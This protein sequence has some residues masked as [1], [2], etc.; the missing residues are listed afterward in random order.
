M[1]K[2][3]EEIIRLLAHPRTST[4]PVVLESKINVEVREIER[5]LIP[6]EDFLTAKRNLLEA[7]H[8]FVTSEPQGRMRRH[9]E[10]QAALIRF[11]KAVDSS[12]EK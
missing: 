1:R 3:V 4:E 2:H 5:L 8:S 6:G 7:V 9:A 11:A 12:R 10:V